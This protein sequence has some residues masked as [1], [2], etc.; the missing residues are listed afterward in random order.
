[1]DST[2]VCV[3]TCV[4]FVLQRKDY[5]DST[6]LPRPIPSLLPSPFLSLPLYQ[7]S[8]AIAAVYIYLPQLY[9]HV[10]SVKILEGW[11]HYFPVA[12][13]RKRG[14]VQVTQM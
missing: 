10:C 12:E 4:C 9:V 1:M 2:H 14:D 5:S 8:K 13:L 6:H 3:C 7:P 11:I